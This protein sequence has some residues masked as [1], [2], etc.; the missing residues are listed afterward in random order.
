M[1]RD[2]AIIQVIAYNSS[3]YPQG[4][5][6]EVENQFQAVH[7]H[8]DNQYYDPT[9]IPEGTFMI[10]TSEVIGGGTDEY[11]SWPTM[12]Y[13]AFALDSELYDSLYIRVFDATEFPECP[14]GMELTWGL[15]D[16]G[17]VGAIAQGINYEHY[18]TNV[19]LDRQNYFEV[20]PEPST[21]ALFGVGVTTLCAAGRRRRKRCSTKTK[22]GFFRYQK[23]IKR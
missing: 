21:L 17:V 12:A 3:M 15:T 1:P 9:T 7:N 23:R 10:A 18:W 11:G 5:P 4:I 2:G 22:G 6:T 8:D 13:L 16:L 19:P 20:I 14:D